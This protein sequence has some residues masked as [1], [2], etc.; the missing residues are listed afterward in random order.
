[1]PT[2]A[3]I[4]AGRPLVAIL[5]GTA[6]AEAV[7]LANA[8]WDTGLGVVEV[9]IQTADAVATLSAVAAAGRERG[10]HCG[11]GTVVSADQVRAA[12]SAGAVFTVA[13]G[14]DPA[15]AGASRLAGLPHVPGVAAATEGQRA[16]GAGPT[17]LKMFPASTLGPRWL[18]EMRGPFPGLSFVA[19]GGIDADNAPD[20]L[21]AGAAAIGVGSA[22]GR[23]GQLDRL[24]AAIAELDAATTH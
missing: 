6:R 2:V 18:R 12:V 5:R 15:V 11:A 8:V 10:E 3:D 17:W 22:I 19:T 7:A 1:M 20:Y 14:F 9:T 4:L 23:A 24:V 13:P 16:V 21:A